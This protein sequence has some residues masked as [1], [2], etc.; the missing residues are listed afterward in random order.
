MSSSLADT[1]PHDTR[2]PYDNAMVRHLDRLGNGLD[3]WDGE[4]G[5][6]SKDR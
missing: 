4:P 6:E 5:A 1:N 2:N 3:Y